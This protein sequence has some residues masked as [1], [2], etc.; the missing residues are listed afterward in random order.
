MSDRKVITMCHYRRPE[1]TR[2]MLSALSA[3]PEVGEYLILPSVEPGNEEVRDLIEAIDFAE[4]RPHF[5]GERLGCNENTDQALALGFNVADYVIHL[6]DDILCAPDSLRYYEWA[7]DRYASD[8][9]V[10]SVSGYQRHRPGQTILPEDHFRV[11][12]RRA[13]SP[14]GWATWRDRWDQFGGALRVLTYPWDVFLNIAFAASPIE[15]FREEV[16]PELSRSQHIGL[17]SSVSPGQ[18]STHLT[19]ANWAGDHVLA[20]GEFFD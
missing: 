16:Y 1:Y 12:R 3:C 9:M 8:T 19:A 10:F 18:D 7:R 13:F 20:D 14:W 17:I 2:R 11:R 4:C 5:N 15:M 6:E